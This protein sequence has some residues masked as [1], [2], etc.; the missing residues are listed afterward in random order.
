MASKLKEVV[1]S[2]AGDHRLASPWARVE[3]EALRY[4]SV[5]MRGGRRRKNSQCVLQMLVNF[6]YCGL[7]TATIAVVWRRKDCDDVAIL[8]PV[9]AFHD[10]LMC[11][12]HQ[13]QA[14]VVIESL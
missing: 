3:L 7:V 12:R 5:V 11:A 8:R 4:V 10:Q 14:V 6:H 1:R 9:V 2:S 13:S